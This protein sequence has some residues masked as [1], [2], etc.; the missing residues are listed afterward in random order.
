M[1]AAKTATRTATKS[2]TSWNCMSSNSF[3]T[4]MEASTNTSECAQKAICAQRSLMNDQLY[5]AMRERPKALTVN[6][7]Q[8]TATTPETCTTC[9]AAMKTRYGSATVSVAS[10]NRSSRVQGISC[11]NARQ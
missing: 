4:K 10:A 11:S 7:A 8:S 5:G 1:R 9:S 2:T 6:P 3:G